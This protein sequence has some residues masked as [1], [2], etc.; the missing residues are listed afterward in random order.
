[1]IARFRNKLVI[2]AVTPEE[3]VKEQLELVFG[4][5]P[6]HMDYG[7]EKDSARATFFVASLLILVWFGI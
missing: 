2:I 7:E 5:Y 6:V 3:R 4:V 1:M